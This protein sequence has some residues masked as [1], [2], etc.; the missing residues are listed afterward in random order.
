MKP[1]VKKQ[2]VKLHESTVLVR[3]TYGSRGFDDLDPAAAQ[4]LVALALQPGLTVTELAEELTFNHSSVSNALRDL[5]GFKFVSKSKSD[6]DS[7]RSHYALSR[8]GERRA[9]KLASLLA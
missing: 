8:A 4:V 7:R 5:S 3:G 2:L 9:E 1:A 6:E